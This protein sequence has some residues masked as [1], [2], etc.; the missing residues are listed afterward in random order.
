MGL[1]ILHGG[2]IIDFSDAK[3]NPNGYGSMRLNIRTGGGVRQYGLATS[4]SQASDRRVRLNVSGSTYYIG[5]SSELSR[6][7]EYTT[8]T[9]YYSYTYTSGEPKSSVLTRQGTTTTATK[10]QP[11]RYSYRASYYTGVTSGYTLGT[12]SSYS[13]RSLLLSSTQSYKYTAYWSGYC[14]ISKDQYFGEVSLTRQATNS[15]NSFANGAT[16]YSTT[17]SFAGIS[18]SSYSTSNAYLITSV[19]QLITTVSTGS[20]NARTNAAG[21]TKLATYNVTSSY[22]QERHSSITNPI[23][24]SRASNIYATPP[25]Y[26]AAQAWQGPYGQAVGTYTVAAANYKSSYTYGY[27]TG[28]HQANYSFWS[29]INYYYSYLHASTTGRHGN[30]TLSSTATPI[31]GVPANYTISAGPAVISSQQSYTYTDPSCTKTYQSNYSTSYWTVTHT[32]TSNL[33]TQSSYVSG[34]T[35]RASYYTEHNFV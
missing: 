20:Y 8:E 21:A 3:Y 10:T 30:A 25:S 1:K 15:R 17:R 26:Y 4:A 13:T 9:T 7:S 6:S 32:L 11:A 23:T 5:T 35:T 24:A 28:G 19:R 33:P 14:T 12:S 22:W 31:G 29:R 2:Q 18:S 27:Q 34:R 16:R